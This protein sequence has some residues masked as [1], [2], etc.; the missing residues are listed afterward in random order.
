MMNH[1]SG[2]L[3][4]VVT[5]SS[6]THHCAR[7]L[8]PTLGNH[9]CWSRLWGLYGRGSS[10]TG[11]L[12]SE[13]SIIS[14]VFA[15]LGRFNLNLFKSICGKDWKL[16]W[17]SRDL[18]FHHI[19]PCSTIFHLSPRVTS[20]GNFSVPA[21]DPAPRCILERWKFSLLQEG[22]YSP[23]LYWPIMMP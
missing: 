22:W 11:V 7:R 12:L 4:D 20:M 19:P 2:W 9:H 3:E 17:G 23:A 5:E 8:H 6:S 10:V 15:D 16:K 14:R 1:E 18:W 21:C 13:M